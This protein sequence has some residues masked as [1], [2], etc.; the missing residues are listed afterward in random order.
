MR[1]GVARSDD[2]GRTWTKADLPPAPALSVVLDPT[3]PQAK[4][5]LYASLFEKG[6]Y[7]SDDGGQTWQEKSRGLGALKPRARTS[8]RRKRV[9]S[10]SHGS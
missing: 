9:A 8:S 10:V 1:G 4:R 2:F 3:S 5:T 7:R 6:V